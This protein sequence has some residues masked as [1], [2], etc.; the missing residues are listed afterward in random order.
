MENH[1]GY[2]EWDDKKAALNLLKHGVVLEEAA[3]SFFDPD[4]IRLPDEKHSI[5]EERYAGIGRTPIGRMLV[6]NYTERG[7][8]IRIISSRRANKKERKIYED[9]KD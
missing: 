4:F 9:R 7:S 3:I 2:F 8:N 5:T 6:T 1:L